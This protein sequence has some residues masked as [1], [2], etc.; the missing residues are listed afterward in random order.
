MLFTPLHPPIMNMRAQRR[1]GRCLVTCSRPHPRLA[2]SPALLPAHCASCRVCPS[3]RVKRVHASQAPRPR[4]PAQIARSGAKRIA[5]HI[6]NNVG[7]QH[8]TSAH[9]PFASPSQQ[10]PSLCAPSSRLSQFSCRHASACDGARTGCPPL[11]RAT[12]QLPAL[13]PPR[14]ARNVSSP[15]R[16]KHESP[17]AKSEGCENN[18][19]HRCA[20][21]YLAAAS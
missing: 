16:L 20:S 10:Q 6:Q 4:P 5:A 14:P 15:L 9:G 8:L 19:P 3:T 17:P 2:T 7:R 12:A 13:A 1:H 21:I 18:P 11:T